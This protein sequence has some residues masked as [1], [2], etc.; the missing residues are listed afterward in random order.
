M[1]SIKDMIYGKPVREAFCNE[2][3]LILIN[4]IECRVLD[5]EKLKTKSL[6]D[7]ESLNSDLLEN[8]VILIGDKEIHVYNYDTKKLIDKIIVEDV[9][10]VK[11]SM[12]LAAVGFSDGKV[13]VYSVI[14]NKFLM[15]F[16]IFKH[17]IERLDFFEERY[18]L[19]QSGNTIKMIDI[20]EKKVTLTINDV[21]V[22][23]NFAVNEYYCITTNVDNE[24]KIYSMQTGKIL[25]QL[26]LSFKPKLM[27]YDGD[28]IFIL[29]D[30]GLN[31]LRITL[32]EEKN[33][34]LKNSDKKIRVMQKRKRVVEED[35]IELEQYSIPNDEYNI[36]QFAAYEDDIFVIDADYDIHHFSLEAVMNGEVKVDIDEEKDEEELDKIEDSGYVFK[37]LTV[38]DS[39]TM[40]LII[41]NTLLKNFKNIEVYEADDGYKC[42]DVLK[43]HPDIDVIFMDWNMPNLN[44][45]DTVDKI[46]EKDI[47]KN[48]KIIM[49]TTEGAKDKVRQMISKGVKGY[50]VKPFKPETITPLAKKMIEIIKEEKNV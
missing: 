21:C 11:L 39:M 10:A 48:I 14:G 29:H 38:D 40:R 16:N 25:H 26:K 44:G 34:D 30:G 49:A 15:N 3:D 5:K 45:A 50:L 47:Y 8:R 18:L 37:F 42:L 46:R 17:K 2:N 12:L 43:E 1:E 19:V 7:E 32:K 22:V 6:I 13:A 31:I 20:I 23:T 9:T 36:V 35:K 4:N 27:K 28:L 33:R 24:L 41:K